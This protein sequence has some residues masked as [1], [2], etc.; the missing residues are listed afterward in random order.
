VE[1]VGDVGIGRYVGKE[2]EERK[3]KMK[4]NKKEEEKQ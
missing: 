2:K 4:R 1:R 3:R